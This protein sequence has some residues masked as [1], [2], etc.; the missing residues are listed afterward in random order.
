MIERIPG[1]ARYQVLMDH[2][3]PGHFLFVADFAKDLEAVKY[4]E[5]LRAEHT[6]VDIIVLDAKHGTLSLTL[7]GRRT[8]AGRSV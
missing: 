6:D 1:K 7:T 3:R 5:K 4:A 2:A 8:L